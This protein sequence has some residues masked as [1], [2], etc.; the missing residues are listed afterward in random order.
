MR[1]SRFYWITSVSVESEESSPYTIRSIHCMAY[2]L[3]DWAYDP[4]Q[5]REILLQ[6]LQSLCPFESSRPPNPGHHCALIVINDEAAS[7]QFGKSKQIIHNQVIKYPHLTNLVHRVWLRVGLW[8]WLAIEGRPTAS[9]TS[10]ISTSTASNATGLQSA[11]WLPVW[12]LQWDSFWFSVWFLTFSLTSS[13]APFQSSDFQSPHFQS[14]SF[15]LP[16]RLPT[17][18]AEGS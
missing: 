6:Q 2:G 4:A 7:L 5:L 17:S 13:L 15:S 16:V 1:S 3:Y 14:G 18:S 9:R 8:V 10:Y 12:R 11:I